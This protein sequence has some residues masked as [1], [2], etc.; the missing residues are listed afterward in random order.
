MN[1]AGESRDLFAFDFIVCERV[2][3]LAMVAF[4]AEGLP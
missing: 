2:L 4:R 3:L 1:S